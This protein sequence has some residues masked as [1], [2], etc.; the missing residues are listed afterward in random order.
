MARKA[1]KEDECTGRFWEGRFKCQALLDEAAEL[2][3]MAYIDLNPIRAKIAETPEKSEFTSI[4]DRIDAKVSKLKI[5]KLRQVQKTKKVEGKPLTQKQSKMLEKEEISS[6]ADAWLNPIGIRHYKST[7]PR[8]GFLSL[9][10]NEYIE[11]I[12]WTGRQVK[13]GKRGAIPAH[14]KPILTR[15][16]IDTDNWVDTVMSFGKLFYRIAG[17]IE[18]IIQRTTKA[19][20]AFFKGI[21]ASRTAFCPQQE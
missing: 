6:K 5:K 11:L 16:N 8:K 14:L 15:L 10:L 19:G 18:S 20:Q 17:T 2:A 9:S 7:N 1:N 4:K 3:C 12:D 13:D 21:T